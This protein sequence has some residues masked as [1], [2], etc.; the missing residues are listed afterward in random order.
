M[1]NA[2]PG[3]SLSATNCFGAGANPLAPVSKVLAEFVK[4]VKLE[5]VG[6]P[7]D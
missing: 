2:L 1:C 3:G 6:P 5:K 7:G 4:Q